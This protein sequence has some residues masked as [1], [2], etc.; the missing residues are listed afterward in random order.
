MRNL[1]TRSR[2]TLATSHLPH[3]CLSKKPSTYVPSRSFFLTDPAFYGCVL[4]VALFDQLGKMREGQK[5]MQAAQERAQREQQK[6]LAEFEK[7][8]FVLKI[9][10]ADLEKILVSAKSKNLK[11][12][13]LSNL[14]NKSDSTE[15]KVE[16]QSNRGIL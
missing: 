2:S 11:M 1:L 14:E 13:T 6:K 10:T 16:Q 9:D 8:P 12:I 15:D 4:I 5:N 3:T 7:A